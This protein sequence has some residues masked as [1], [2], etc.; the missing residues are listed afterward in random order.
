MIKH[1]TPKPIIFDRDTY[2]KNLNNWVYLDDDWAGFNYEGEGTDYYEFNVDYMV[3]GD[4]I[5]VWVEVCHTWNECRDEG[6]HWTP[7]SC[8][9]YNENHEVYVSQIYRNGDD[10]DLV[11]FS[12]V[13]N[14]L[15]F[16]ISDTV[17]DD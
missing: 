1:S 3:G 7:P 5:S 13:V 9:I 15:E 8:D 12:D 10:M 6:D 17:V 14:R 16:F 2:F 11:G 4:E